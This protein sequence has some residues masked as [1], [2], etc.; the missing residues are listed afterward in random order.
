[1]LK[2]KNADE[3]KRSPLQIFSEAWLKV[4]LSSQSRYKAL[5]FSRPFFIMITVMSSQVWPIKPG[6][7]V[8]L[9]NAEDRL[10]E[11]NHGKNRFT[12]GHR[13]WKIIY[14]E[15]HPDWSSA[16][17]R[18]KYLKSSAGKKWLLKYLKSNGNSSSLPDWRRSGGE[19][20]TG[21]KASRAISERLFCLS[22]LCELARVSKKTKKPW[23]P[24]QAERR[25]FG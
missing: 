7:Q 19:S 14:T 1:M 22:A 15:Q 17:K 16:R 24:P 8:W 10:P 12:K 4:R 21:Y 6:I 13:P 3:Q 18:E 2:I 5:I 25:G 20:C 11:H 23:D 9:K